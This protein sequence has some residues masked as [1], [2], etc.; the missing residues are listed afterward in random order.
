MIARLTGRLVEK[1]PHR[2]VVDVGGIGYGASIPLSTFYTLPE[3]GETVSLRVHTHV[4]EDAIA[5]YGFASLDE[6]DLF[7]R[8]IE[9]S[10]IGPRLALSVLSGLPAIDLMRAIEEGD[11]ARLRGIPGVGT[12]TADRIVLEMRDRVRMMRT[13]RGGQAEAVH[14]S[15]A[16]SVR[17][18]VV[19]ALVNLGYRQG[20]AEEA[21]RRAMDGD[22]PEG[23]QD[24]L[25]RSLRYLAS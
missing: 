7:E 1:Q 10:G 19:S 3:T 16:G 21:V 6:Q 15:A 25:K 18:D 23:L 13:S 20:Q 9:V 8:L 17:V 4:R 5:L 12:K 14:G 24:V 22:A 2:V 11:S